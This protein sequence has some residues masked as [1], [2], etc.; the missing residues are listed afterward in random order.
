MTYGPAPRAAGGR[1][2]WSVLGAFTVLW[3]HMLVPALPEFRTTVFLADAET[4]DASQWCF[5]H[6]A[7]TTGVVT[8]PVRAG[9][10]AFRSE[11]RDGALIYDTERSEYSNGP[12]SC[13]T[14]L[15]TPGDETWTAFS[16][17]PAS[18]YPSY[19]H[20][21]LVAQWKEPWGGTPP[22]L[23]NLQNDRWA[24]V[25]AD[26]ITPRPRYTFG[27]IQRGAWQDFVVHH[28][29][30]TDPSIGFVE[31]FFNGELVLPKTFTRTLE[32]NN[33][34]FLSVGQYRDSGPTTGTA[35]LFIDEVR[36]DVVE[37]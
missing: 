17:Y 37:P 22:Q 2:R 32:N 20:W 6:S 33:P 21:S 4:G 8:S 25:G 11:I 30:S 26:S 19:S 16:V 23:L 24:I 18:D 35:V 10:Y 12:S 1:A 15:F 13:R 27:T 9:S 36:V 31:V 5:V 7:I 29:W 34:V 14:H 3:I 28:K